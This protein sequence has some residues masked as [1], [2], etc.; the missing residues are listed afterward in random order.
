MARERDVLVVPGAHFGRE[1]YLRLGYG[2]A[3]E[4]LE[5]GLHQLERAFRDV[6]ADDR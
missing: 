4:T 5:Q 6:D 1:G 3:M 2:M